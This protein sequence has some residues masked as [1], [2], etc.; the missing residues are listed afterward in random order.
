MSFVNYPPEAE[1]AN[2]AGV[3]EPPADLPP[4]FDDDDDDDAQ[5]RSAEQ[6]AP[7]ATTRRATT[8]ADVLESWRQDGP[9][10]HEPTGLATL[11]ELT[12]GGPVYGTRWY[13]SGAPDAGKTALLVMI[14]HVFA[15]RGVA[16]GLLAVDEEAGDLVTRLAQR[17]GYA[18]HHCE[19]RDLGVLAEIGGALG[20]LPLRIYDDTWTIETA[21]ADLAAWARERAAADPEGHPH[22]PRAMLGIDSVQTVTCDAE[23]LAERELGMAEAVTQRVRAIRRVATAHRL[24]ALAASELG[25]ASYA[26]PDP[27]QRTSA[28]A[29]SKWSGAIEYSARVLAALRSVAGESDLLELELAK[30]KH[31]PRTTADGEPGHVYLRIDRRAQTLGEVNYTPPPVDR[32]AQRDEHKRARVELDAETVMGIVAAQPGIGTRD[33]I[34]TAAGHGLSRERVYAAIPALGDRIERRPGK[35]E[36]KHH[37]P[38]GA[39]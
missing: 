20:G 27:T 37:F 14:A 36:A 11:D 34:S 15:A 13:L 23:R 29:G 21:A 17:I 4:L 18:R 10:V 38:A 1:R 26:N 9:L 12:G 6:P 5:R 39:P 25:R 22:G 2:G 32:E 28:L 8:V 7:P 3:P 16:V 19:T 30:N 35:R 33:L 24:I 31:G